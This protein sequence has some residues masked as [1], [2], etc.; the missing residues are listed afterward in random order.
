MQIIERVYQEAL[1]RLRGLTLVDAV[2]GISFLGV[3]LSDGSVHFCYLMRECLPS[4]DAIF[5]YG[6]QMIGRPA[7]EIAEWALIGAEDL[8]RGLGVATLCAVA[9]KSPLSMGQNSDA[10]YESIPAASKVGMIGYMPPIVQKLKDKCE[11]LCFDRAVELK[12]TIEDIPVCP[13]E[14][15]D[16]RLPTCDY[17]VISGTSLIN[18]SLDALLSMSTNAQGIIVNGF[19]LPFYPEA[20]SGTAVTALGAA[21]FPNQAH[22][23]FKAVSLAAGRHLLRQY[24]KSQFSFI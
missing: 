13:M 16:L 12:G 14:E 2:I 19:S 8:K 6:V 10:F 18:H 23:L 20:F 5:P 21:R 4:G 1:P 11:L 24:T 3:Q 17:V 7:D 22:E 15:Q 9:P